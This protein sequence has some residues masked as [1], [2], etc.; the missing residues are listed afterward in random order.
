MA[1]YNSAK[2]IALGLLE[3]FP[4]PPTD[5]I[6]SVPVAKSIFSIGSIFSDFE[7]S[8]ESDLPEQEKLAA[9]KKSLAFFDEYAVDQNDAKERA[10]TLMHL[11][12][13]NDKTG[14]QKALSQFPAA[15][16]LSWIFLE[17][18][19]TNELIKTIGKSDQ[20]TKYVLHT[21][22]TREE[23]RLVQFKQLMQKINEA[24]TQ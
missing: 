24:C 11:I 3:D 1:D 13:L 6:W 20:D 12:E 22:I 9:F 8:L 2:I 18:S 5:D 14:L 7:R 17:D 15:E 4:S 10:K 19:L 23:N 16:W 21:A